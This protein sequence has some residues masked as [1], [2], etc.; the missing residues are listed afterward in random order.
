M[1]DAATAETPAEP[2]PPVPPA[3]EATAALD[4]APGQAAAVDGM[5]PATE[6]VAEVEAAPQLAEAPVGDAGEVETEVV[7][8]FDPRIEIPES[9]GPVRRAVLEGLLD[10]EGPMSVSELHA[11]MPVGTPRGTTEAGILREYRSGRIL[12]IS[13]GH[14]ALAPARPPE[15]K[16]PSP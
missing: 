16:R 8:A 13:P 11:L 12:R 14:Y 2:V 15:A 6:A 10:G 1:S 7:G 3:Q 5:A 9:L 4:A